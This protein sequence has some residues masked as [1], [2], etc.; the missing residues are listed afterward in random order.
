LTRGQGCDDAF[1]YGVVGDYVVAVV[2]DG[3]GS[4]TGTSAWGSHTACQSVLNAAMSPKFIG[5][6]HMATAEDGIDVMRWLF[7]GALLAVTAQAERMGLQLAQLATTLCVVVARPGLAVFGQIGDGVIAAQDGGEISTL[8]IEDKDDYANTTWFLQSK[9][10]F[11]ESFRVEVRGDLAAFALSTDGMSYKITNILTGEAFAPFFAS[12]WDNVKSGASAAEFAAMLRG[13]KDDQTGDDKTM[14]L[15]ALRWE[16]D[17]FYP[18]SRPV[19]VTTVS[20]AAPLAIPVVAPGR[21]DRPQRVV[22]DGDVVDPFHSDPDD[23]RGLFPDPRVRGELGEQRRRPLVEREESTHR[24]RRGPV[25]RERRGV[26][27][28]ANSRLGGDT[29]AARHRYVEPDGNDEREAAA[30]TP[31]RRWRGRRADT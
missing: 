27:E 13:I 25:E 31:K 22:A 2:A 4:V 16:D 24:E 8:L 7:D 5:D 17:L 12:A 23:D 19:Q 26:S 10:S 9:D 21:D 30:T 6:F 3:A 29:R 18:S 20:S 1:G 14:V 11:D 15:A 28:R